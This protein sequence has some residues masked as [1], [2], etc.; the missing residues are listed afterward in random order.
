MCY[1]CAKKGH[2]RESFIRLARMLVLSESFTL[3]S[4]EM[5][6]SELIDNTQSSELPNLVR[7]FVLCTD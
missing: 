3:I 6:D 7:V 4:Q 2:K 1:H 5:A